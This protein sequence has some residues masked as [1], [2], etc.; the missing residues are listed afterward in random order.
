MSKKNYKP[1][2][3]SPAF[4]RV[5]NA[6]LVPNTGKVTKSR[7][8]LAKLKEKQDQLSRENLIIASQLFK[9]EELTEKP[10]VYSENSGCKSEISFELKPSILAPE[11][12]QILNVIRLQQPKAEICSSS[13]LNS[14]RNHSPIKNYTV[15][16]RC[17]EV[18]KDLKLQRLKYRKLET[19][20]NELLNKNAHI[21]TFYSDILENLNKELCESTNGHNQHPQLEELSYEVCDIKS[22]LTEIQRKFQMIEER[23]RSKNSF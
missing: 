13:R 18:E 17:E 6:A 9:G 22:N 19:Q 23:I 16:E 11:D 3:R 8:Y 2:T 4:V 21:E 12:E 20:Y 7:S 5:S 14:A 10:S 15:S 1:V